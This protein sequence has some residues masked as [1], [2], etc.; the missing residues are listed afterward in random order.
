MKADHRA[1]IKTSGK[2]RT[3]L[4]KNA[5]GPG[6]GKKT[7]FDLMGHWGKVNEKLTK[8]RWTWKKSGGPALCSYRDTWDRGEGEGGNDRK[9]LTALPGKGPYPNQAKRKMTIKQKHKRQISRGERGQQM[10]G[11]LAKKWDNIVHR[12]PQGG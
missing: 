2:V 7:E 12:E 3:S 6:G 4:G 5:D 10:K 9:R 8:R 1:S 11:A